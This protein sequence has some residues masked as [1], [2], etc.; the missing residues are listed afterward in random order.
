M[1]LYTLEDNGV[2]YKPEPYPQYVTDEIGQRFIAEGK[3]KSL[4]EKPE[5]PKKRRKSEH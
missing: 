4:D 1:I 3:A 5:A 2:K